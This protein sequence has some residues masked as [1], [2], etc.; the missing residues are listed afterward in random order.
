MKKI[1]VISLLLL[2]YLSQAAAISI[3]SGTWNGHGDTVCF[4]EVENGLLKEK[5]TYIIS[6]DKKFGFALHLDKEGYYVIGDQNIR[7]TAGKYMFYLKPNDNLN[8]NIDATGYE[9]V[10]ENTAE[11]KVMKE[12]FDQIKSVSGKSMNTTLA[13]RSTYVDFFPTL[14]VVVGATKGWNN[15]PT[16]NKFFDDSF[17]KLK[18]YDLAANALH[19]IYLPKST[20]PQD[21]D[22][23]EY[24]KSISLSRLG[25]SDILM[26]YY[27]GNKLLSQINMRTYFEK[28]K[29]NADLSIGDHDML[30]ENLA[31]TSNDVLKGELVLIYAKSKQ[32]VDG[33]L[34]FQDEFAK[35]LI[36]DSQ[37]KR[38]KLLLNERAKNAKGD[39][40]IDFKFQDANGKDVALSDFKGKVVYI[41]VWATWCGPCKQEIPHLKKLEEEYKGKNIVFLGVSVDV[42]K[43]HAKWKQFL[44]DNDMKG[45]QIFAGDK[46]ADISKPYKVKSYPR[47]I[48]IDKAGRIASDNAPRPSSPEIRSL[49]NKTLL[50]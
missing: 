9:L 6:A 3:V 40:A 42:Q 21:E 35:Y 36:T 12:W 48:L 19:Y 32:T 14:E 33:L 17:S 45:V 23:P 11:N 30:K 18:D 43:D 29:A 2:G 16:G 44:I 1:L 46:V 26:S 27:F 47:F 13:N 10:G 24:Y 25:N 15:R 28:K 8:V 38:F 41:D 39:P 5:A 49:L 7:L 50:H 4:Y 22:F 34:R 37:K 31:N 20:H